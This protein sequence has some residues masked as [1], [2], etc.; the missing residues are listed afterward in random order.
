MPPCRKEMRR[1][2]NRQHDPRA[3]A[4]R[5]AGV[6]EEVQADLRP[7]AAADAGEGLAVAGTQ[8]ALAGGMQPQ[9]RLSPMA[10][11]RPPSGRRC[12]RGPR[13]GSPTYRPPGQFYFELGAGRPSSLRVLDD[14][15]GL[16][17]VIDRTLSAAAKA[18]TGA[19]WNGK[20][21]WGLVG[22][23]RKK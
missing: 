16:D 12:R 4:P 14:G 10:T 5:A 3:P 11:S 15:F 22:R 8:L 1:D 13:G 7:G 20:L 18:I 9:A 21:F 6:A 17:G 2:R 23:K 19:H